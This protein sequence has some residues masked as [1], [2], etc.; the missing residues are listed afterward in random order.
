MS[1]AG[2]HLAFM[3]FAMVLPASTSAE[4]PRAISVCEIAGNPDAFIGREVRAEGR[5]IRTA[6]GFYTERPECPD[7]YLMVIRAKDSGPETIARMHDAASNVGQPVDSWKP[8]VILHARVELNDHTLQGTT[9][10]SK[11]LM[12]AVR[13]VEAGGSE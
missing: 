3:L 2:R 5:L 4:E 9:H 10:R 12:L 1:Y 11:R 6:H 8:P 7:I 13:D